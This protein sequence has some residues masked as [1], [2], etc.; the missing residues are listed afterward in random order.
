MD[1]TGTWTGMKGSETATL[2]NLKLHTRADGTE[3]VSYTFVTR[4]GGGAGCSDLSKFG[5]PNAVYHHVKGS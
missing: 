2:R 5:G 3:A 1:L 4:T